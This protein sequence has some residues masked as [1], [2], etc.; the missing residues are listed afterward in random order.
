MSS[1]HGRKGSF[2]RKGTT[3]INQTRCAPASSIS[4]STEKPG[5]CISSSST[6][7]AS[8]CASSVMRSR[9]ATSALLPLPP[10]SS[11]APAVDMPEDEDEDDAKRA[12]RPEKSRPTRLLLPL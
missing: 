1:M 6:A 2:E 8:A 9:H 7:I 4:W 10:A 5:V 12:V 11:W 3:P